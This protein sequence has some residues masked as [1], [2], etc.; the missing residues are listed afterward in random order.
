VVNNSFYDSI[1]TGQT[2]VGKGT[3]E[4]TSDMYKWATFGDAGWDPGNVW[5]IRDG[6]EYPTLYWQHPYWTGTAGDHLF[7]TAANWSTGVVPGASEIA[8][9]N[10]QGTSNAT[11]DSASHTGGLWIGS[12]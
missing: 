9:F 5:V 1:T 12:G 3:P 11:V 7:S 10:G 6:H 4:S 2:D 8:I